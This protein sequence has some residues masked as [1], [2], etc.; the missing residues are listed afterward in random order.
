MLKLQ[1]YSTHLRP[2]RNLACLCNIRSDT[3]LSSQVQ[4]QKAVSSFKSVQADLFSHALVRKKTGS[5]LTL[6][7]FRQANSKEAHSNYKKY[8]SLTI[9]CLSCGADSFKKQMGSGF[10]K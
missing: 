9:R 10:P 7:A 1:I 6:G 3:S 4:K 2:R 8:V 5:D